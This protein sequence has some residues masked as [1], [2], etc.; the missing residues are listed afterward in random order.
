VPDNVTVRTTAAAL[1]VAVTVELDARVT[2]HAPVP[3]QAPLHPA[4]VL[5]AVGVSVNV[6]TVFG[7]K[8]AEQTVPQLIPPAELVTVPVPVPARATVK[9]SPALKVALTLAAAIR[10]I[11]QAL[12]PVQLPLQPPKK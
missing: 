1:K 8:L 11:V 9:P 3:V 12:V 10:V 7:A 2:L 5:P 6:T 4:N